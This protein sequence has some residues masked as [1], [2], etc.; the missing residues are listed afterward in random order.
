MTLA[1]PT[2]CVLFINEE[3]ARLV[4]AWGRIDADASDAIELPNIKTKYSPKKL[5]DVMNTTTGQVRGL[6]AQAVAVGIIIEGGKIS[7]LAQKCVNGMIAKKAQEF[8]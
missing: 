7:D 2:D 8:K 1:K 4:I 6:V 3:I 5:A